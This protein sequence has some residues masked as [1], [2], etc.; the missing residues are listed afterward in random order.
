MYLI[1]L[2]KACFTGPKTSELTNSSGF[3]A[4]NLD[5]RTTTGELSHTSILHILCMFLLQVEEVP[6][7]STSLLLQLA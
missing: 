3:L 1:P 7:T 4:L 6:S 5:F 2:I